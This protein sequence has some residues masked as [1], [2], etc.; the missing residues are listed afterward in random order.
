MLRA[1]PPFPAGLQGVANGSD[2]VMKE[3]P[4]EVEDVT[5]IELRN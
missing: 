1:G 4:V 5:H 3:T 2:G